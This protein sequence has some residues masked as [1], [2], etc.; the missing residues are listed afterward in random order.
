MSDTVA[1]LR[2]V[3]DQ[4]DVEKT[5]D[6]FKDKTEEER[7]ILFPEILNWHSEQPN[8]KEKYFRILQVPYFSKVDPDSLPDSTFVSSDSVKD[9]NSTLWFQPSGKTKNYWSSLDIAI[10]STG[11]LSQIL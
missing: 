10:L 3:L 9:S 1:S 6:F 5:L 7:K 2:F 11:T 4:Q 8:T